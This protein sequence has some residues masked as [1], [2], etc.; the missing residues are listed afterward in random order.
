MRVSKGELLPDLM[1]RF[2]AVNIIFAALAAC[3]CPAA[4]QLPSVVVRYREAADV[5]EM[6]DQ[7]SAWWPEY[8]E[9][10]YRLAWTDA[11]LLQPGD[12]AFFARYAELRARHFDRTGQDSHGNFREGSGLFTARSTLLADPMASAFYQSDSLPQALGLL[13]GTLSVEET[14]FLRDFYAHFAS[15]TSVLAAQTRSL[16]DGSRS[17]TARTLEDPDVQKYLSLVS[18]LFAP[19]TDA[20][21]GRASFTALYVWWPDTNQAAAT[22][23]GGALVL[24][25]RPRAGEVVN[26]ADVVAHETIHV[27]AAR[28]SE[29]QQQS[30]SGA[31]L[32]GCHAPASL[33]R[34]AILEEPIATALGNI[35]FRRRFMPQRFSWSRRWY[36]DAWVN[37]YARLLQ[38]VLAERLM[39]GGAL[40]A[41]FASDAAALCTALAST[42]K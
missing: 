13:R 34:L 2:S 41:R 19:V 31:L 6:L 7:V 30:L 37:V 26:S 33:R 22:P 28:V 42:P 5:F 4:A 35:E 15:R 40:D 24:R 27:F 36:G 21:D 29:A 1:R 14:D 38:P 17:A 3:S 18:A 39:T 10:A 32:D 16:T 11:H 12:S 9:P 23:N 20:S 25:V 8:V